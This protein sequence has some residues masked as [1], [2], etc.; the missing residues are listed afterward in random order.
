[1]KPILVLGHRNPDNDSIMS[2]IAYS[3]LK[4][5]L[6]PEH[7]YKPVR[8]GPLP[9]ESAW[10]LERYGIE[11][12]AVVSNLY[13]RVSDAMTPDPISVSAD[14]SVLTAGKLMRERNIMAVVVN[15]ADGRYQGLFSM[16]L[17]AELFIDELA[18][19]QSREQILAY[20]AGDKLDK[21]AIVLPEDALLHEVTEDI[22]ASPLRQAVIVDE[23][24][25][26][27]GIIT[28]TDLARPPKRQVILVDHNESSQAAWGIEEVQVVGIVDHH[29]VGDIQTTMPIQFLC[30]PVG[31]TATIVTSEYRKNGIKIP[32]PMAAALLSAIMT[33]TVLLRSPTTTD[34][35]R[36]YASRLGKVLGVDPLEFGLELFGSRDLASPPTPER[37]ISAD[38]KEYEYA[39]QTIAIIQY[40]TVN[41]KP[42]MAMA[43][44]IQAALDELV[45][46]HGYAF[47]LLLAT[48]VVAEGSQVLV[49]GDARVV[50]RALGIKFG[51]S[52]SAPADQPEQ[53]GRLGVW[54]PG[55]LS[56]KKQVAPRILEF[57]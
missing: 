52:P 4:S 46:S 29:R 49:G 32:E 13:A 20:R 25:F 17:L 5:Q 31:S 57:A 12:P 35:D 56:R 42:V 26:C 18:S 38:A 28:R 39:D 37:I 44:D 8:L 16:R 22:L 41:L 21:R 53:L 55:I 40:E 48:D 47:A 14:D 23:D 3:Y 9:H 10:V 2:A 54:M 27:S 33:D 50:E 1:M 43:A 6:D 30:L 15:G 45:A 36:R 24:G 19:S 7:V 34:D 11:A 51:E